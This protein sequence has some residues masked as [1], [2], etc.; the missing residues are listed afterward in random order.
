MAKVNAI[1]IWGLREWNAPTVGRTRY[2]AECFAQL[3]KRTFFVV[4]PPQHKIPV[5]H[6]E[7]WQFRKK[8]YESPIR[9]LNGVTI[10]HPIPCPLPYAHHYAPLRWLRATFLGRQ[11]QTFLSNIE[12][13]VLI[14]CDPKEWPL[15]KWWRSRGG[16]SVYDC[17]DLMPAFRG[18]G[19]RIARDEIKAIF[20]AS[21]VTCS[22]KGLLEHI[23]TRFP[24]KPV[25]LVRNGIHWRR[26]QQNGEIPPTLKV[27]PQPRIGFVGSI[28]YWIDIRLINEIARMYPQWHFIFIGPL[29]TQWNEHPL[30]IHLLPPI[31]PDEVPL[32]LRGIDV[33]LVPFVD[34]PLTRCVNPLKLY[35][36]L[37][38][39]KPVVATP[40][41]DF[42]DVKEWV[43]FGETPET[44]A[45][46]IHR[47]LEEDSL[48]LQQ[49]RIHVAKEAD[50]LNRTSYLLTEL[51]QR[52]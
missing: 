11:L 48:V 38:C 33:G 26:F 50:W 18:A 46:A 52:V 6:R 40:Y 2:L 44:F 28:S 22:S 45:Q 31:S 14:V 36:Y 3:G 41:G 15:L 29:K 47:A 21:L 17:A 27:I 24:Q 12:S 43:Y 32:Y 20:E 7:F 39:G 10:V 13:A 1:V 19:E 23:T 25:I 37:A 16:V 9:Q 51:D 49:A 35:E 30:N 8:A 4:P 5:R 34:S 42:E